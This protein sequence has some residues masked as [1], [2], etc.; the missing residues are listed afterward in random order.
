MLGVGGSQSLEVS[1]ISKESRCARAHRSTAIEKCHR[2]LCATRLALHA[3]SL[4]IRL[5][6]QLARGFFPVALRLQ[7]RARFKDSPRTLLECRRDPK[8]RQKKGEIEWRNWRND[9]DDDANSDSH[10]INN[11]NNFDRRPATSAAR[12]RTFDFHVGSGFFF[13]HAKE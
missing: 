5:I 4:S 2:A 9:E 7:A 10:S 1:Q 6:L 12:R 8:T 13:R 3:D 11:N